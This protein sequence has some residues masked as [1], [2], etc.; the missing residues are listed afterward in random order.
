MKYNEEQL[1][2]LKKVETV[3]KEYIIQKNDMELIWSDKLG[4]VLFL[5]INADMDDFCLGPMVMKNARMLCFYMLNEI[6][7]EVISSGPKFHDI[8]ESSELEREN[9]EA[10]FRPY[11]EQ[12]PGYEDLIE[13]VF[14]D[15]FA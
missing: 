10:V 3:F 4:Y 8:H 13:D 15:P 2:E 9:I 5:G 7:L 12:L 14:K 1:H 6:A 11:L